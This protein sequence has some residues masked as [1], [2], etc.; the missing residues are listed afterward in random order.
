[1][2]R[3]PQC[4]FFY[5]E[6]DVVCDFDQ[7][8]LEVVDDAEIDRV[9]NRPKSRSKALPVAALIGLIV[10]VLGFAIY[11]GVRH[12][13][14][15]TAAE[16]TR[17]ALAITQPES[18]PSPAETALPSPSP[19]IKPSPSPS[20]TSQSSSTRT[21]HTR[22]TSDPISTSGPGMGTRQGGKP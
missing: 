4:L 3:C 21:A 2:K 16:A 1:M 6:S 19:T 9:T 13:T 14:H 22:A 11:Y 7:T 12:Q 18:L 5:P 8:S 20:P 10:G 17:P 15:K